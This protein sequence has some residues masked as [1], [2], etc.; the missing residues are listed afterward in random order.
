MK[1]TFLLFF[2]LLMLL[3][4]V[5]ALSEDA[6]MDN[7]IVRLDPILSIS[8]VVSDAF[9][10]DIEE[11]IRSGIPTSFTFFV[12][13]YRSRTLWPDGDINQWTFQH[14]VKYD[15]L[16]EEY[17][18]T[19]DEKGK[20]K[21]RT[22]DFEEMKRLMVTGEDVIFLPPPLLKK[23]KRYE[24]RLMAELDTVKLP[25]LLRTMLFFVKYWDFETDWY[26]QKFVP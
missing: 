8:F 14:T 21:I 9:K 22:K 18:I 5:R 15:S 13:L 6:R 25:F 10:E 1:K 19:L 12:E 16:K 7:V 11:A 26:S 2:L 24:I 20:D 23:G 3:A 4:P 17:E